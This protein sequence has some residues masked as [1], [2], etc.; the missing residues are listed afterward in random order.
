MAGMRGETAQNGVCT[1][2][3]DAASATFG[4]VTRASTAELGDTC[5]VT[6]TGTVSGT[7]YASYTSTTI[8]EVRSP[9]VV[10]IQ[11]GYTHACTLFEDGK[12][13][14]W[15]S[16]SDDS[17]DWGIRT[18]GE[19]VPTR[20][21]PN[22]PFVNLGSG[23]T[24]K[25]VSLGDKHTCAIR[26]DDSLVCWGR[27]TTRQLGINSTLDQ[28]TPP[29][30]PI[31]LGSGKTAVAVAA[32][33]VHTCALLN[34]GSVKCWGSRAKG[35]LG[36]GVVLNR[37]ISTPQAVSLGSGKT[38]KIIAS[39]H[40]NTCAIL[41]DDSLVCWGGNND[42]RLGLGDTTERSTPQAVAVGGTVRAI[43]LS[44]GGHTCAT[45]TNNSLKCWGRNWY[46]QVG[47]GTTISKNSPTAISLGSG[48]TAKSLTLGYAHTCAILNDDTLK[49][50]G[51]AGDD[52]LGQLGSGEDDNLATPPSTAVDLGTNKSARQIGTGTDFSCALLNDHTVKC[53]GGNYDGKLGAGSD[54][55]WGDDS[56]EMGD[57]LPVVDL[58]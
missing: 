54:V 22:L 20:W 13:K 28:T 31:N 17:W 30:N 10:D 35:T 55:E 34:D 45:L 37:S 19:T 18:I 25:A 52:E 41:N 56:G 43:S 21:V 50:W 38:A 3:N 39:G 26:N 36:N 15:G 23:K 9:R 58:L 29:T 51:S 40:D 5:T 11:M 2:D 16:N 32:G 42:G 53:W 6:I 27:S 47:D 46:G 14:C 33:G 4:D 48:K 8:L 44:L 1:V 57:N 24:A 49:C 7:G 12:L